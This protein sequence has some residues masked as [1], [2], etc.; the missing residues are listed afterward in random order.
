M[1]PIVN[2]R[3][4]TETANEHVNELYVRA[5]CPTLRVLPAW[6]R[7]QTAQLAPARRRCASSRATLPP[8]KN[9]S[10]LSS[11]APSASKRSITTDSTF[12]VCRSS[13]HQRRCSL[14]LHLQPGKT[15]GSAQGAGFPHREAASRHLGCA[16]RPLRRA[17]LAEAKAAAGR[18]RGCPVNQG[19]RRSAQR[20]RRGDQPQLYS[21]TPLDLERYSCVY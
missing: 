10:A 2:L 4:L 18:C 20:M 7:G 8:A 21:C 5:G 11:P 15:R 12:R 6:M 14:Q 17:P 13:G 16:A 3:L 1:P 9:R 19:W